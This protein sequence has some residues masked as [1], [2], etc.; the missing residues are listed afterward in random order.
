MLMQALSDGCGERS[1]LGLQVAQ[2]QRQ[3]EGQREGVGH[4]ERRGQE[5]KEDEEEAGDERG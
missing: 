2:T 1:R 4:R 5:E 3:R